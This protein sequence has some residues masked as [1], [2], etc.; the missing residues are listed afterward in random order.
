MPNFVTGPTAI[1]VGDHLAGAG[2]RY[3]IAMQIS[4]D[5]LA[6]VSIGGSQFYASAIS[7]EPSS[8]NIAANLPPIR[9][10][11]YSVIL[12]TIANGTESFRSGGGPL[13]IGNGAGDLISCGSVVP[14]MWVPVDVGGILAHPAYWSGVG[15]PWASGLVPFFSPINSTITIGVLPP[16]N[17]DTASSVVSYPATAILTFMTYEQ[18]AYTTAFLGA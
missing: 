7:F 15:E 6:N 9:A 1:A 10:V 14:P 13:L 16:F 2:A 3:N 12:P 17:F 8:L 4:F 5:Q 11:R 18:P